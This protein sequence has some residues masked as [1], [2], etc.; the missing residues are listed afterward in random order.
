MIQVKKIGRSERMRPTDLSRQIKLQIHA[1][2]VGY[3]QRLLFFLVERL[4][5]FRLGERFDFFALFFLA[6]ISIGSSRNEHRM[7]TK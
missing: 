4:L 2:R 3:N 5:A 7:R 6:A 1:A